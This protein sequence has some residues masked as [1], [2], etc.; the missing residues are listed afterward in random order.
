MPAYVVVDIDVT[1]PVTYETYRGLAPATVAAY[2]GRYLARGGA[3]KP[4][5]GTWAP[6]RLVILEF[7][8]VDQAKAWI[9][10]PEYGP[11]KKIRH[12]AATSQMVVIAGIT[13]S[14]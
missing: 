12:A 7:P 14:Q 10:S 3:A 8:S 6:T 5:E 1:D 13:P 4:L 11:V 2:G 9:D